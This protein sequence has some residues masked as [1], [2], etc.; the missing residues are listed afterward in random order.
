[1]SCKPKLVA[2]ILITLSVW[3][4]KLWWFNELNYYILPRFNILALIT[5]IFGIISG[6]LMIFRV[7]IFETVAQSVSRENLISWLVFTMIIFVAQPAPLSSESVTQRGVETD[8]SQVQVS[9]P[10]DFSIDSAQRRFAD[11]IKILSTSDNVRQFSGEAVQVTGFVYRP[12]EALETEFLLA[13]FVIRCCSADARP[14]VLRVK[15]DQAMGLKPDTWITLTGQWQTDADPS[16]PLYVAVKT[17][18][19]VDQPIDPYIY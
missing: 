17:L 4:C 5:S 3:L 6:S 15:T 14:V 9:T 7:N 8:L 2:V 11:W 1:M 10:V 18:Q 16:Q 19:I 12:K 13:R